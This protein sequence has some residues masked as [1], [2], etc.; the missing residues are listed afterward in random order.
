MQMKIWIDSFVNQQGIYIDPSDNY[1]EQ[2]QNNV[3]C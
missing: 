3:F 1:I 2:I